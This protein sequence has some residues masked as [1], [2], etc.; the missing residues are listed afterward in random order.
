MYRGDDYGWQDL[1]FVQLDT[2]G[3]EL[4]VLMGMEQTLLRCRPVVQLEEYGWGARHYGHEADSARRWLE[5]RGWRQVA[6][7]ESDRVLVHA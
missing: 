2:E 7:S 3:H 1:D 5:A 4:P 6:A